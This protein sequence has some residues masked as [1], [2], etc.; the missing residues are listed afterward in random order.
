M[1]SMLML[2]VVLSGCR[3]V[4]NWLQ[5]RVTSAALTGRRKQ[6]V[7]VVEAASDICIVC[8][9]C[10][11]GWLPRWLFYHVMLKCAAEASASQ[12]TRHLFMR[13]PYDKYGVDCLQ[14]S[15]LTVEPA[16]LLGKP[17]LIFE[18]KSYQCAARGYVGVNHNLMCSCA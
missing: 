3:V 15:I 4:M 5:Y 14:W 12:F 9:V 6:T 7:L 11:L 18:M 1:Q 17:L 16:R 10:V 13:L 2:Y 8:P